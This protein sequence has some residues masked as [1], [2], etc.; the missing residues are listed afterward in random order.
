VDNKTAAID[1]NVIPSGSVT[2]P[3][4]ATAVLRL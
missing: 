1:D 3:M 2:K 4:T